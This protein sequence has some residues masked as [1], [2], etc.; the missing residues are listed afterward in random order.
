MYGLIDLNN[1]QDISYLL[2]Q[3][4]LPFGCYPCRHSHNVIFTSSVNVHI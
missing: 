4:L 1:V 2:Q 3:S